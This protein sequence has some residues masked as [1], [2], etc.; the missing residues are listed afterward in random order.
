MHRHDLKLDHA[1]KPRLASGTSLTTLR[2]C[3]L[4]LG[5]LSACLPKPHE[6]NGTKPNR[7]DTSSGPNSGAENT[8][9]SSSN[10]NQAQQQSGNN[11]PNSPSGSS[12]TPNNNQ[13][14]PQPP[15]QSADCYKAD[16]FICKIEALIAA[17]T[18]KY[19]AS[20]SLGALSTNA[21]MSF[22][23]RDWSLKQSN[24]GFI[25]HNGFPGARNTVY[26]TEF[27]EAFN[28]MGENVA[29]TSVGAGSDQSDAAAER[30][31]ETFAVM[32]WNSPGHRANMLGRFGSIG[33][34]MYKN[35]RGAWYATQLFR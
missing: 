14:T 6:T 3:V 30:I 1:R 5:L 8:W 13:P 26:K 32:W 4:L 7:N 35:S 25:S 19:R 34:G 18:N 16:A 33:V 11:V 23:A 31:A 17:K 10:N 22:V 27:Q 9:P 20:R 2:A 28:F 12:T 21:K 29:Y 15:Q 24:A